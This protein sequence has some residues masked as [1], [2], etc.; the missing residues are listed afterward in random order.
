MGTR[1]E[2]E[3]GCA[4]LGWRAVELGKKDGCGCGVLVGGGFSTGRAPPPRNIALSPSP[5]ALHCFS[6]SRIESNALLA[7]S[8]LCSAV[9]C[10][11]SAAGPSS[12]CPLLAAR[13]TRAPRPVGRRSHGAC[14]R[15]VHLVGSAHASVVWFVI[16]ALPPCSS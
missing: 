3:D 15:A 14:I 1:A 2:E 4:W 16:S 10:S 13:G 8:L 12:G 7:R 9:Q 6:Y 5:P 11:A